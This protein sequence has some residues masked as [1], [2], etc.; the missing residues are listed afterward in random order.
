MKY[1]AGFIGCGNMG[2]ALAAVAAKAVGG[3]KILCADHNENKLLA[4]QNSWGAAIGTAADAAAHSRYVILGVKP[5]VIARA[6]DEI[7]PALEGRKEPFTVVT[8]AAGIK[9]EDISRMLGGCPVIRIMPNTPAS[10][11]EGMIPYCVNGGVT[12]DDEQG[13]LDLFS[14]AGVLDKLDEDKIDMAC[15]VSG[16]GPAFVCMFIESL[17]DGAVKC[18]LSRDKARLYALQTVYGTARLIMESGTPIA[19]LRE[20][21]CSPGGSTIA[22]VASMERRG[23]RSAVIDGVEASYDRTR[24]L[25]AK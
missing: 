4:L 22:G 13:F 1:E 7:R 14:G 2:G 17:I 3:A 23:L 10:V 19:Q 9:M 6:A 12:P 5:Q 18:G 15:A 20:A 24:E 11:G 21:V 25:G 16:C 8:M